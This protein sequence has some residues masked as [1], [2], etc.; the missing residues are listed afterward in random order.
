MSNFL[1]FHTLKNEIFAKDFSTTLLAK[2]L[3]FGMQVDDNLFYDEIENQPSPAYSFLY[4]SIFLSSH[5]LNN[6]IFVTD[7]SATLQA[8]IAIFGIWVDDDLFYSEIQ[9]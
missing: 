8:G 5:I 2:I 4:L 9:N 1:S 3:I 7:F 6:E